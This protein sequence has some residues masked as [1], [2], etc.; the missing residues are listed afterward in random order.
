MFLGFDEEEREVVAAWR[1]ARF[2]ARNLSDSE[3]DIS[4]SS[5]SNEDLSDFKTKEKR[6]TKT[7]TPLRSR[8][9]MRLL[10]KLLELQKMELQSISFV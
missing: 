5:V 6:G 10:A 7:R 9:S 4:V 1:E 2:E 8:H 3:S